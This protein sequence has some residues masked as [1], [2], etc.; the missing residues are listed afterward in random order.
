MLVPVVV[1]LYLNGDVAVEFYHTYYWFKRIE[2]KSFTPFF[3]GLPTWPFYLPVSPYS[4][5]H[6]L[7]NPYPSFAK[8]SHVTMTSCHLCAGSLRISNKP[9]KRRRFLHYGVEQDGN[10]PKTRSF[11]ALLFGPSSEMLSLVDLLWLS[12]KF[13]SMPSSLSFSFY[14]SPHH[15][16]L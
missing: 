16:T 2:G 3:P 6:V 14:F 7:R 8:S 12:Y 11:Q 5:A 10:P 4:H 1:Y 13:K 15:F 9:C